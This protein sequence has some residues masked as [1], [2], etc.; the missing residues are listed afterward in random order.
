MV[1][2]I[3]YKSSDDIYTLGRVKDFGH[4]FIQE[5]SW[6]SKRTDL[7]LRAKARYMGCDPTTIKKYGN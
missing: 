2:H 6:I 3:H 4:L 1:I 5:V 7:S